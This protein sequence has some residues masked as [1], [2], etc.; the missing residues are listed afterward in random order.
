M[1]MSPTPEQVATQVA[2]IRK[3][4]PEGR[5]IGIYSPGGWTG[6]DDI[7][8]N[9][10]RVPVA[11]CRSQL[12]I[13]ER[14]AALGEADGLVLLTPLPEQALSLDILARMAGRKLVHIDRWEMVR[15]AF[16]ASQ[17][18]PRLPMHGWVADALLGAMPDGGFSPA[19]SGWLDADTAWQALLNHYLEIA[20]GRPDAGDLIQWSV[21]AERV[22]RYKAL[23]EPLRSGMRERMAESAGALGGILTTVIEA[24]KGHYL[25]PIGLVCEVLFVGGGRRS[26][27]LSQAIARLEPFVGGRTLTADQGLAWYETA[28]SVLD[29]LPAEDRRILIERAEGLL[30]DLKAS[31]FAGLSTVFSTGFQQRLAAFGQ[32]LIDCLDNK[33]ELKEIEG[34]FSEVLRHGECER[35]RERVERLEMALKLV[36]RLGSSV[37]QTTLTLGGSIESHITDGVFMDWARRYLLGGDPVEG[38]ANAFGRLYQCIRDIREHSESRLCRT[39]QGLEQGATAGKRLPADRAIPG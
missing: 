16:S 14:F 23:A 24:G 25:L 31:Q 3:H 18:D 1:A 5:V 4:R 33:A 22:S 39:A 19:P 7:A 2:V 13:S 28:R 17:V 35:N 29:G 26:S 10:E 8:V 15:E 6:G 9:G 12:E 27:T 34:A 37:P 30:Q 32:A 20:T 36:R 11:F 21:D 38:L